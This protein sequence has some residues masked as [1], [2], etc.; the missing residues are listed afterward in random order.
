MTDNKYSTGLGVKKA[1]P[2]K[3]WIHSDEKML[4]GVVYNVK[5]R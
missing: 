3:T 1:S 5:V 2:Q 4:D